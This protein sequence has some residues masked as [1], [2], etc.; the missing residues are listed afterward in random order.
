MDRQS[1][2]VVLVHMAAKPSNF[3]SS[4]RP[5]G[6]HLCFQAIS[7]IGSESKQAIDEFSWGNADFEQIRELAKETV[8]V[9]ERKWLACHE[10]SNLLAE[11]ISM[12]ERE[13]QEN[14]LR[15]VLLNEM[16]EKKSRLTERMGTLADAIRHLPL[17]LDEYK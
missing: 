6:V 4:P 10:A 3:L 5:A 8:T 14:P 2:A 16:G 17:H 13:S 7:K 1:T 12:W 15:E 11:E 9:L